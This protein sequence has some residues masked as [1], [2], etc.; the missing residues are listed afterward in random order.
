MERTRYVIMGAG[1][2]GFHLA[3]VL[4]EAGHEVVVIESDPG[5]RASLEEALDV[6]VV[7]GN[8]AY[9]PVLE[10]AEVGRAE[11]LMAVSSS[12]EA[13]MVASL[14]ARRLGVRRTVVRVHIA[15]EVIAHR[16]A[17][18][19]AFSIDLL[20][21]TQLLTTVRILDHLRG[22]QTM[23]V[24]YLAGGKVQLRKFRLEPNSS[25]TRAPLRD[26][27]VPKGALVVGYFRH[28]E[29]VIPTGDDQAL[30]GDEALLLASAEVMPRFEEMVCGVVS[31]EDL[32]VIGG[33]GETGVTVADALQGWKT[34]V[35]L[36]E[37]NR[38]R[39]REVADRF[40]QYEVLHGD[41]TDLA[42]LRAERVGG[43]SSF[44]AC[45]GQDERNLMASLLAQELGVS[46]VVALV[47]RTETQRLWRRLGEISI[48][49]PRALAYERIQEYVES[50]YDP[51]IVSLREGGV[52][53]ER[54]LVAASPA[55]GV[56][57]AE[58]G[59]PRGIIVGAVVRG[60]RVFVPRG[61]DRLEAGDSV[62]LF[63]REEE[64]DTVNLLFPGREV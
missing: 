20:L 32:V 40:P 23:A 59:T 46:R 7:A 57:L 31:R 63:V 42:F 55:A 39:A 52:F 34:K 8:G 37:R 48:V 17:Y 44:V 30:P 6:A 16:R 15:E 3:R 2:V 29:L 53:V 9:L 11:L 26:I 51:A 45:T 27:E 60:D 36:I 10:Q 49:S 1:E 33:A 4:S 28:G 18:Q 24:E 5:R 35:K 56:T 62:I 13:N 58:M 25:L 50:G 38:R 14:L 64:L 61:S 54:R 12:D 47:E 41:A 43:A 19:D 21:S 22:H